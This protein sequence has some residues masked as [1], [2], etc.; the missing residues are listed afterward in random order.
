VVGSAPEEEIGAHQPLALYLD[1]AVGAKLVAV[2]QTIEGP[3]CNLD[4]PG[5]SVRLHAV[6]GVDSVAREVVAELRAP[7]HASDY[8][9]GV[10]AG[11]HLQR[12]SGLGC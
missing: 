10:D 7:D 1:R 2:S 8:W 5:W 9:A 11:S 4:C 3:R 6:G 12:M